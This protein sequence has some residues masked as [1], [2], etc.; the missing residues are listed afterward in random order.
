[1]DAGLTIFLFESDAQMRELVEVYLKKK[2]FNVVATAD[3]AG[4]LELITE[5]Q[6]DLAMVCI[7]G[8]DRQLVEFVAGIKK[9]QP[10]LPILTQT[11]AGLIEDPGS[12]EQVVETSENLSTV[13]SL[14][15]VLSTIRR[16]LTVRQ[17]V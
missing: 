3:V 12:V 8:V 4:S 16:M 11:N 14:D 9:V 7:E 1:M 15:R 5:L 13:V 2:G 6:V 17:P 10:R